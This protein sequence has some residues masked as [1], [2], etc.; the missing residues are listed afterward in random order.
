MLFIIFNPF[1][2][3]WDNG[4]GEEEPDNLI[5]IDP[6]YEG[7][8]YPIPV[9]P[10]LP[11]APILSPISPSTNTDGRVTLYWTRP[12]DT[13]TFKIYRS[14]NGGV[15]SL[16]H[17]TTS[18]LII[19]SGLSD[20]AYQYKVIAHNLNGDSDYSNI[21]SVSVTI[22]GGDGGDGGGGKPFEILLVCY[23]LIIGGL[24]VGSFLVY[25]KIRKRK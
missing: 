24:G 12:A 17:I 20:G 4:L 16:I 25:K 8:T 3:L 11:S 14:D 18:A 9:L 19:D 2:T 5:T 7:P 23:L 6:P 22:D 1:A 15:F 13:D 21:E 10:I